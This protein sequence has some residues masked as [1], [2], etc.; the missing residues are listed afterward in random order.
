MQ[1]SL[2][3]PI[4]CANGMKFVKICMVPASILDLVELSLVVANH[5]NFT[6]L[7]QNMCELREICSARDQLFAFG[8]STID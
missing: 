5:A 4:A 8:V 2:Y 1:I 3:S 7:A 6:V